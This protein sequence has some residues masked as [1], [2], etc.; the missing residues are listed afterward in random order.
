MLCACNQLFCMHNSCH[1]DEN[2]LSSSNTGYPILKV[3][4]WDIKFAMEE[5]L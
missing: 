2:N 3:H 1:V 5:Y 4:I